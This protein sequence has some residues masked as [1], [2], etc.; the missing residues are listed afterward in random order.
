MIHY[1]TRS[2]PF[3]KYIILH[4]GFQSLRRWLPIHM[5][6]LCFVN[7]NSIVFGFGMFE[8]IDI[9][10]PEY[11]FIAAKGRIYSIS[12]EKRNYYW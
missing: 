1:A 2:I 4:H 9:H 7:E 6:T 8:V 5:T 11:E 12:L 3:I 10:T